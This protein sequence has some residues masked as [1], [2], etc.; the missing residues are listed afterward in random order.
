MQIFNTFTGEKEEFVPLND[1]SVS[2]Y[3]CGPTVYD[4]G[5]VGHGRSMVAFDVVRKYLEYKGFDVRFVTNYTDIDDK[6]INRAKEE[7]I[8]VSE[9]AE[10]IIPDYERDFGALNIAEPSDRPYA[11]SYVDEM[12]NMVKAL[13]DSGHAYKLED[14]VYFDTS[15]F[16]P[17]GKLS[18]QNLD[19]LSHGTRVD[20]H[21]GKK[22]PTDFVLWKN[23]KE[24]E[25]SWIDED[26]VLEEG[27]PGW[28][29]ECSAMTRALLGNT[30][31][32]H[33]GGVDLTFPHHECE[34]AQSEACNDA[35]FVK[36]WMHNGYVNIDGEKMSKSL[37]NFKTLEDIIA[38]YSGVV[39]RYALMSVHYRSPINFTPDLFVQAKASVDRIQTFYERV[40][41]VSV[42]EGA[43]DIENYVND[44][45]NKFGDS[46][47]NDFDISGA[48]AALFD[49]IKDINTHLD[50]SSISESNKDMILEAL[51]STDTVFSVINY[52]EVSI[53]AD[54]EALIKE[55]EEARASKDY[56]RS[57]EIRDELAEKGVAIEDT[58]EGTKWKFI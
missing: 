8:S 27:R 58:P 53:D 32:I 39:T 12:M 2:M 22:N 36:Y 13:I 1:D 20:V 40:R 31:D 30:F 49:F 21:E 9:L 56:A 10:K 4:K 17:Y 41:D 25:P 42:S 46:M 7:G 16:D 55:R 57:D 14:G 24:G 6:M 50:S 35:Q 23:K 3:V 52:E 28:H 26:G 15:K 37:N 29:I 48:L 34:I 18:G 45:L 11:T 47:D 54:V 38:K 51:E 44:F 19:E 33:G 5:H 43:D